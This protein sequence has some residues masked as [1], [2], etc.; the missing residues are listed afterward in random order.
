MIQFLQM[1]RPVLLLGCLFLMAPLPAFAAQRAGQTVPAPTDTGQSLVSGPGS[2]LL[3][4]KGQTVT[5]TLPNNAGTLT[6]VGGILTAVAG[7]AIDK[8]EQGYPE[9]L[10]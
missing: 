7:P 6:F 8:A 3:G 4:P 5:V 1:R 2:W 10:G 9:G